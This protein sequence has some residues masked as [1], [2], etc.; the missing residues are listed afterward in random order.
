MMLKRTN[1]EDVQTRFVDVDYWSRRRDEE[2][3]R[4]REIDYNPY[5]WLFDS[6]EEKEA[7]YK[8]K[9]QNG[10]LEE[11]PEEY[12]N[13]EWKDEPPKDENSLTQIDFMRMDFRESQYHI[14]KQLVNI[15][16][17]LSYIKDVVI[18]D[19]KLR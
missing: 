3:K 6:E 7:Y 9:E 14:Y 1:T 18:D 13:C 19:R 11:L 8:R 5:N 4:Q 2:K 10:E 17:L 15:S 16:S 12:Y